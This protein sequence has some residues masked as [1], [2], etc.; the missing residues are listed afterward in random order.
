M[1]ASPTQCFVRRRSAMTTKR[2]ATKSAAKK[3]RPKR[4]AKSRIL[5]SVHES[6]RQLHEA[7]AIDALTMR[8]FD[9]LFS[10]SARRRFVSGRKV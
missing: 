6:A 4:A 7:G 10:M 5:E 2:P 8:K 3:A 9:A 1:S